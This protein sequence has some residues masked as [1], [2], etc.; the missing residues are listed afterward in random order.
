ML[1]NPHWSKQF[2][3]QQSI[4]SKTKTTYFPCQTSFPKETRKSSQSIQN[5]NRQSDR[6][7]RLKSFD[8]GLH[9]AGQLHM[10]RIL[11][12]LALSL[13]PTCQD[14]AKKTENYLSENDQNH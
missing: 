14:L 6:H 2:G 12:K 1:R 9:V 7:S 8:F 5:R 11:D 10:A 13:Q 3:L 4:D